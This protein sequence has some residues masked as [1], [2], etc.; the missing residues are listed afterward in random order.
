M[1]YLR[2]DCGQTDLFSDPKKGKMLMDVIHKRYETLCQQFEFYCCL[3]SSD[4]IFA[5]QMNEFMFWVKD[6]GFLDED[7]SH[8]RKADIDRLFVIVNF[9]T[10]QNETSRK[11]VSADGK[12]IRGRSE[13]GDDFF[14][15]D[16]DIK[17][18]ESVFAASGR[19][20][21]K[22]RA[23]TNMQL[24]PKRFQTKVSQDDNSYCVA[25]VRSDW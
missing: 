8:C 5:M 11:N 19:G 23:K 20:F 13:S 1:D 17:R 25:Q 12:T 10:K 4:D 22:R 14:G 3:G 9:H 24:T 6:C 18:Y 15:V 21:C 16:R 7:S 2:K